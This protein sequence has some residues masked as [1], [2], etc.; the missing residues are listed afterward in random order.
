MES[1]SLLGS[2]GPIKVIKLLMVEDGPGDRIRLTQMLRSV[3]NPRFELIHA[4][5]LALALER[6]P[7]GFDVILLNLNLPDS[8]YMETL[9]R[10][11]AAVPI[12]PIIVVSGVFDQNTGVET[13]AHGACE[14]MIEGR[15]DAHLLI[16]A[17]FRHLDNSKK[18][19]VNETAPKARAEAA[20][21]G[22]R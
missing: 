9:E 17:I 6:A 21:R 8:R 7:E 19:V 10:M 16:T 13:L 14:Y 12:T 5:N 1:K 4:P 22:K 18:G 2:P 20:E 3:E 11:H 15:F